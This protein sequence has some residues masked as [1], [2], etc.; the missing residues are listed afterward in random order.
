LGISALTW[1]NID[2]TLILS[3]GLDK[4]L[5]SWNYK[6]GEIITELEIDEIPYGLRWSSIPSVFSYTGSENSKTF[7]YSIDS[8]V[9][10]NYAPRWIKPPV[11]TRFSPAG[12]CELVKFSE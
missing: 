6:T 10:S 12:I 5:V 8:E 9:L 4:K 3:G 11:G 7:I 1:C 2:P